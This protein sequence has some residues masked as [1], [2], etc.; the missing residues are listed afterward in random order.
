MIQGSESKQW[1]WLKEKI[2]GGPGCERGTDRTTSSFE[3]AT[4][5]SVSC[6]AFHSLRPPPRPVE[7][8][9]TE[10]E[11]T[12]V[13]KY[14]VLCL[15]HHRHHRRKRVCRIVVHELLNSRVCCTPSPCSSPAASDS[16]S[17]NVSSPSSPMRTLPIRILNSVPSSHPTSSRA[18]SMSSKSHPRTASRSSSPVAVSSVRRGRGRSC[19]GCWISSWRRG[20]SYMTRTSMRSSSGET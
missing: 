15:A 6:D 20:E 12:P 2:H 19:M 14:Y 17:A 9:P 13:S 8:H 4:S 11:N 7:D 10:L 3:P 1:R 5:T 16:A 18:G